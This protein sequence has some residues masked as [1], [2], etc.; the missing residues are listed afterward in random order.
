[1]PIDQGFAG[2]KRAGRRSKFLDDDLDVF[3]VDAHRIWT[4]S[5]HAQARPRPTHLLELKNDEPH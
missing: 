3:S 4:S 5:L 1:M 2:T